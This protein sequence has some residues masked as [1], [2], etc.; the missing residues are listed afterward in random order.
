[1]TPIKA[2]R[3]EGSRTIVLGGMQPEYEPLQAE[4]DYEGNVLTAW[5][6]T[7]DERDAIAK[8]AHLRLWTKTFNQPFHP[9]LVEVA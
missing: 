1:M 8:G 5:E 2:G 3:F 6:F 9:V 4:I 7:D